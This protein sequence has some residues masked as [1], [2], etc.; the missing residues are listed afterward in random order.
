MNALLP[1]SGRRLTVWLVALF[2]PAIYFL[3]LMVA[4]RLHLPAPPEALVATLFFLIPVAGLLVAGFV[5]SKSGMTAG[6]KIGWSVF[7]LLVIA[8]Q[9]GM[10]LVILMAVQAAIGYAQ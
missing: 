1:L 8:F 9:F 5:L 2:S 6:R 10:I 7:S 3:F 4:D